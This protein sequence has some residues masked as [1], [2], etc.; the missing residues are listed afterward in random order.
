ME[1]WNTTITLSHTEGEIVIP[2]VKIKRG[3]FQGD[4]LSPLLFC[5][6]LDPLSKILN[7]QDI[8]Y[9]LSRSRR[10]NDSKK[11]NHLLF[12]DDLKLYAESDQKLS[13]LVRIVQQFSTDISMEFGL[14]KCSKCTVRS[15][16][17]VAAA[18]IQVGEESYIEDLAEDSTYKYLGIEENATTEHRIVR[19]KVK[20]EYLRRL[21]KICKS[22]LSPK[23]R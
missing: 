4:S 11:A 12:M 16:K 14:D 2:N 10:K 3:I 22:E 23:T 17:K 15:G 6:T 19:N 21:K 5:L 8:G 13:I 20:A 9:N 18:N 7:A 1:K